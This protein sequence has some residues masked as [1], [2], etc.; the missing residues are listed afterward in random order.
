MRN[1]LAKCRTLTLLLLGL[2]LLAGQALAALP[3]PVAFSWTVEHGD[4]DK[5]REWLDEGLDPDFQGQTFG[6]GLMNAAWHGNIEMMRLFVER[7]ADPRR[8]NRLGEQALQLAAWNGHLDAVKWLLD[9]G[10]PINRDGDDWGALHYAVF[11]GHETLVRYL[12]ER[13]ANI[14]ARS[15]NGSTPLMMA[16]RE[17][18]EE[19]ARRLLEAGANTRSKNDWGDTA[20]TLA[21]RYDHYR[22]GKLI[23]SPEEFDIAVK[24]PREDP[25]L[26]SRS[27]SAP[28]EIDTLLSKVREAEATGQSSEQLQT[29]LRQRIEEIRKQA[30]A[31]QREVKR[32][33][34]I[35]RPG[36]IV[37]TARR[38]QFGGERVQL[39]AKNRPAGKSASVPAKKDGKTVTASS[40][41]DKRQTIQARIAELMRQIRLTEAQGRPT[42]ALWDE[43]HE[44]VEAQKQR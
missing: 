12:I 13:G 43:L 7:G 8:V 30:V 11:N 2:G 44:A 41:P 19:L 22:V 3:D 33:P 29:R 42:Q 31:N 39:T 28:G 37:I 15:P 10:A 21:V 34:V 32:P 4:I 9:H 1:I 26:F 18:R 14:D 17:G 5:A 24:A 16:A 27:I 6:T 23:A 35:Y 38:N 36:S 25:G 20:L 40:P